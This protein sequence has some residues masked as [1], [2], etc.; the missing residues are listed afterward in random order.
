MF[1]LF[2][3]SISKQQLLL[4]GA[5]GTKWTSSKLIGVCNH[6]ASSGRAIALDFDP[7]QRSARLLRNGVVQEND[8]RQVCIDHLR[9]MSCSCGIWGYKEPRFLLRDNYFVPN[10][11]YAITV[12]GT[13]VYESTAV[14][15]ITTS[16]LVCVGANVIP[17]G[18]VLEAEYGFRASAALIDSL[19]IIRPDTPA[20]IT[21]TLEA[22][23]NGYTTSCIWND[24]G[25]AEVE[26]DTGAIAREL[27][28]TYGV[29]VR[30][31]SAYE[32]FTGG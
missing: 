13:D 27:S 16:S 17:W 5:T 19:M 11:M 24:P 1:R 12:D 2:R 4:V 26:V 8:A 14:G 9:T 7:Y 22:V 25:T 30:V 15:V 18:V 23:R 21:F 28:D 10:D 3:L 32:F 29:P 6:A 31:V 20:T